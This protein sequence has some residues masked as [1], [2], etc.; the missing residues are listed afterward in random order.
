MSYNVKKGTRN[1]G[2]DRKEFRTFEN[3]EVYRVAREFQK[4]MYSI[5]RQ[6]PDFDEAL[7]S[8]ASF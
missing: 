5:T 8:A 6:L 7:S 4:K 1:K 2:G 3:L